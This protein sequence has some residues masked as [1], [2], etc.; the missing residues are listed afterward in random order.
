MAQIEVPTEA[1]D[2]SLEFLVHPF[3]HWDSDHA[4]YISLKSHI[5]GG[6]SFRVLRV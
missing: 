4:S 1:V 6:R 5:S 2:R 3:A